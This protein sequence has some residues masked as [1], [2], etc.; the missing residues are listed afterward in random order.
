MAEARAIME[1]MRQLRSRQLG[2]LL[3]E[4]RMVKAVRLCVT[5][6]EQLG[7]PW[8]EAARETASN[9]MGKGRWI[10]RMNNGTTLVLKS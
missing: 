3:A 9:R 4:C 5:W 8:A 2:S 1:S 6:A 10:K 7:L